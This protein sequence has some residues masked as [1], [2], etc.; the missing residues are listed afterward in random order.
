MATTLPMSFDHFPACPIPV[1]EPD[2]SHWE[3][4]EP[5][6]PAFVFPTQQYDVSSPA[7]PKQHHMSDSD[8]STDNLNTNHAAISSSGSDERNPNGNSNSHSSEDERKQRRKL[9]NR[10]S[11]RRSRL[12]K[13]RQLE[14]LSFE[15]NRLRAEN[16]ELASQL[17]SAMQRCVV[18]QRNTEM[19]RAESSA[20]RRILWDIRQAFLL[21]QL[22]SQQEQLTS[23]PPL[24]E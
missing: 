16:R 24:H 13:Q 14:E 4:E 5:P 11:A 15:L 12:R 23:V 18:A 8:S 7:P 10:D 22:Q 9:S 17:R 19:V 6:A 2:L 1:F 20:L 21:R 3:W